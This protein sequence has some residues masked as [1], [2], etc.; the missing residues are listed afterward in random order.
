MSSLALALASTAD[1]HLYRVTFFPCSQTHHMLPTPGVLLNMLASTSMLANSSRHPHSGL[2]RQNGRRELLQKAG[3]GRSLALR[4]QILQQRDDRVARPY[5]LNVCHSRSPATRNL[6][7]IGRGPVARTL[8][9]ADCYP[10]CTSS[11]PPLTTEPGGLT[12]SWV[13]GWPTKS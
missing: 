3:T 2:A 9:S 4:A 6:Y 7:L 11:I 13:S 10:S 12:Q 1:L 5:P 8:M